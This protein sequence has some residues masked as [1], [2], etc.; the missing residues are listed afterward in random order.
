MTK[1]N[2]IDV[3]DLIKYASEFDWCMESIGLEVHYE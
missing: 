2:P 1:V 3:V